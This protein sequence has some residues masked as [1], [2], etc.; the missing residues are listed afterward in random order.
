[1]EDLP[2]S[3]ASRPSDH[4]AARFINEV[5]ADRT[6]ASSTTR[7]TAAIACAIDRFF[8]ARATSTRGNAWDVLPARLSPP[9]DHPCALNVVRFRIDASGFSATSS[10]QVASAPLPGPWSARQLFLQMFALFVAR[11]F[12]LFALLALRL[13]AAPPL[14]RLVSASA[15]L[16]AQVRAAQRE[17]CAP[18]PATPRR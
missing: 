9:R 2:E 1:L 16:R 15:P 17:F 13:S 18:L 3:W 4:N 6:A 5:T 11:G 14:H 10:K 8:G 12:F 7:T